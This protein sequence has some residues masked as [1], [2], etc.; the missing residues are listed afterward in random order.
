MNLPKKIDLLIINFNLK[1][2]LSNIIIIYLYSL[3]IPFLNKLILRYA[4]FL[5]KHTFSLQ[6]IK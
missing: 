5:R 2:V 3:F 6:Q 4:S 1:F